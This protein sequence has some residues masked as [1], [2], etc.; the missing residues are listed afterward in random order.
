MAC[1]TTNGQDRLEIL[2]KADSLLSS[3]DTASSILEL[4]RY[5]FYTT[6][7]HDGAQVRY[8][9]GT[10]EISSG[11][12]DEAM[13]Y[14]RLAMD[15]SD[16]DW[17]YYS[18]RYKN[19]YCLFMLNRFEECA[20]EAGELIATSPFT[21]INQ[22]A[23]VLRI[24]SLNLSG[25]FQVASEEHREYAEGN[26]ELEKAYEDAVSMRMK[27]PK[28]AKA[29]SLLFPGLGLV[30]AGRT[31]DGLIAT[32]LS[33][34]L[35][36]LTVSGLATNRIFLGLFAGFPWFS[37]VYGGG[38]RFAKAAATEWN[39]KRILKTGQELNSLIGKTPGTGNGQ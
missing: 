23:R 22:S 6:D 30:Y 3:G 29:L 27:N 21:G 7:K 2:S 36:T 8:Q 25:N 26:P 38:A 34:S 12:F 20:G 31:L 14:F 1:L 4:E 39:H 32:G 17:I 10:I 11:D 33:L 19:A 18:A 24:F 28:T 16:F 35:A 5:A 37:K 13:Q 9:M 15:Q